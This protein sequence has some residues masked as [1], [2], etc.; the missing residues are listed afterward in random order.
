MKTSCEKSGGN[1]MNCRSLSTACW[2]KKR[3]AV[4]RQGTA[5]RSCA[6]AES[7]SDDAAAPLPASADG[8]ISWL[9]RAEGRGWMDSG[10]QSPHQS[11]PL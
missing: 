4:A 8:E 6:A 1:V 3:K 10:P 11:P 7:Q 2:T 5:Q 9:L